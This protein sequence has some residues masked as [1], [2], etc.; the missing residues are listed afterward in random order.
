MAYVSIIAAAGKNLEIGKDN[1]LM[2]SLPSRKMAS[3]T[4][5]KKHSFNQI[6]RDDSY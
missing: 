6:S 2:W 1:D 3:V 5:Q 4:R